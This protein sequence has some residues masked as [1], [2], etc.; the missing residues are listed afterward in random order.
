MAA[1]ATTPDA[2]TRSLGS[3]IRSLASGLA[4]LLPGRRPK[5][6]DP[7]GRDIA[8][9]SIDVPAT[10]EPALASRVAFSAR[11]MTARR[12]VESEQPRPVFMDRLA[13]ALAGKEALD[14]VRGRPPFM[15]GYGQRDGDADPM[16]VSF[17]GVRTLWFDYEIEDAVAGLTGD[18]AAALKVEGENRVRVTLTPRT[19]PLITQV[20][21]LGAG[22]DARPWRLALPGV[23][24]FDV[25]GETVASVKRAELARAGAQLSAGDDETHAHPLT[26]ASYALV[27]ADLAKPGWSDAVRQ[28]GW[29]NDTPSLVLAE[30]L[31]YYVGASGIDALLSEAASLV[32]AGTPFIAD[33]MDARGVA[34]LRARGVA[35]GGKGLEVAWCYGTEP[36]VD[37]EFS[38]RGWPLAPASPSYLWAASRR[39]SQAWATTGAPPR[40]VGYEVAPAGATLPHNTVLLL[41]LVKQK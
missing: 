7:F 27:T 28:A 17:L 22:L 4:S 26:V 15:P 32:P 14:A 2:P 40:R 39:F 8:V 30:G 25:D 1:V 35:A 37:A 10:P 16:P 13:S 20:L 11:L 23:A 36:D 5:A 29:R 9:T 21:A 34:K 18:V 31:T 33:A 38:A 3:R 24:W 41:K 19:G 6:A 12:A